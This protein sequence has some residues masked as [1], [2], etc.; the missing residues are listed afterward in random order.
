MF[1][2]EL[3]E[4]YFSKS[5]SKYL[6]LDR[7]AAYFPFFPLYV[8]ENLSCQSDKST[9]TMAMQNIIVVK[10]NIMSKS[11]NYYLHRPFGF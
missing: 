9:L 2:R 5:L 3:L 8:Y 11:V 6:Q 1:G 7:K 4:E 10:A